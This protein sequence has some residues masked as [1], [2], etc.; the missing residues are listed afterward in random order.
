MGENLQKPFLTNYNLMIVQDLLQPHC[1]IRLMILLK[2]FSVKKNLIV[3]K[4]LCCSRNYK[5]TFDGNLKKR[6]GN[7]FKISSH[8]FNKFFCCAKVFNNQDT[9]PFWKKYL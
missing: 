6:F 2:E 8:E 3:R 9:G 7:T 1:Q 5:E 4:C